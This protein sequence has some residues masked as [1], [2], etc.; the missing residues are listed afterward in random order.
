MSWT[1]EA[2]WLPYE[3]ALNQVI[4]WKDDLRKIEESLTIMDMMG[5]PKNSNAYL[6]TLKEIEVSKK[7]LKVAQIKLKDAINRLT[8]SDKKI[9]KDRL[10]L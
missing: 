3:N 5:V 10:S 1:K 6:L 2:D 7:G 4:F 9:W 8:D